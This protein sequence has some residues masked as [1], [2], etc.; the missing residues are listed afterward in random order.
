M[1]GPRWGAQMTKS[2]E[3]AILKTFDLSDDGCQVRL[4]AQGADGEPIAVVLSSECLRQLIM[5]MPRIARDALR[6]RYADDRLRIVY[7]VGDWSVETSGERDETFVLTLS[8]SDGYE[9]SFALSVT[10]MHDFHE[11]IS[12]AVQ[13][14]RRDPR[15]V[16]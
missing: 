9:V 6:R 7:P 15:V 11:S 12:G 8:A 1:F 4:N 13:E 10:R 5:T 16:N 3:A 2:I 14:P